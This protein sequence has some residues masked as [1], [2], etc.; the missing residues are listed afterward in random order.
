MGKLQSYMEKG[1]NVTAACLGAAGGPGKANPGLV[2]KAGLCYG[3]GPVG[4]PALTPVQWPSGDRSLPLRKKQ[5]IV[6]LGETGPN[7][8]HLCL[9]D[10]SDRLYCKT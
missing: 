9:Q 6:G 7:C 8:S 5:W 3:Q 1:P 4:S 2:T 10:S